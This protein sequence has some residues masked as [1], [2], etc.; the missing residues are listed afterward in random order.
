MLQ[1]AGGATSAYGSIQAGNANQ[2]MAEREADVLDYRASLAVENGA[3]AA[4][5]T[6][7]QGKAV[8]GAQKT[9]YA[10]QGVVVGDGSSGQMLEQTAK[11][12]E[13]DA[14]QIKLNAAREAWGLKEQAKQTRYAGDMAKFKGRMDAI[15]GIL[16]TGGS[17]ASGAAK[18]G[19]FSSSSTAT[20]SSP[21]FQSTGQSIYP[22]NGKSKSLTE[23]YNSLGRK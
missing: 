4:E 20:T 2:R 6:R 16:G 22:M 3:F 5:Q 9:G 8:Q 18:S 11:L 23:T 7:K 10:A 17:M 12:S 21:S 13:Q 19:A 15:G 1:A 14:L